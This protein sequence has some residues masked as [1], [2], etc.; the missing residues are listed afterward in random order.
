MTEIDL[1]GFL[2]AHSCPGIEYDRLTRAARCVTT[3]GGAW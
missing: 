1:T 2:L 3:L